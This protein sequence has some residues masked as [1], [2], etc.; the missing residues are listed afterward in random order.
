M[1]PSRGMNQRRSGGAIPSSWESGL[2]SKG[3]RPE[4]PKKRE[5]LGATSFGDE[6]GGEGEVSGEERPPRRARTPPARDR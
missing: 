1:R 6:I 5:P 2:M 3:T 4:A